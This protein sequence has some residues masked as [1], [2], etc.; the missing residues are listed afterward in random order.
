[1]RPRRWI[2]PEIARSVVLFLQDGEELV[3]AA[4]AGHAT[5]AEGVRIPIDGSTS[6]EV[7]TRGVVKQLPDA[8]SLRIAPTQVGVEDARAGEQLGAGYIGAGPVWETPSKPDAG[9]P[10]GL[11][12]RVDVD[13][14]VARRQGISIHDGARVDYQDQGP[15]THLHVDVQR[16]VPDHRLGEVD[17]HVAPGRV[18]FQPQWD[19]PAAGALDCTA[20]LVDPDH[21]LNG[22]RFR[23]PADR[24]DQVGG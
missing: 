2:T 20:A 3:V 22:R 16:L 18:H 5:P 24:G 8:R 21:V 4:S 19:Q 14:G 1:M 6:G 7:M 10:I 15:A 11:D 17:G 23:G 13:V 9:R 12:G